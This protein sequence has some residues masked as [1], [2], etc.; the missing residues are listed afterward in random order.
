CPECNG[1]LYELDEEGLLRFRC[2]VGHAY[3]GETLLA[4]Q[5]EALEAALWAALRALEENIALS[6]RLAARMGE[7]GNKRSAIRFEEK[8][9]ELEQNVQVLRRALLNQEVTV[10]P[11]QE[12]TPQVTGHQ[13]TQYA[14][15]VS[16]SD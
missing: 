16:E 4:E 3:S 15:D 11:Q 10:R 13:D 14:R 12:M 7:R 6:R 2:R 9:V 5:S 1:V 8:A